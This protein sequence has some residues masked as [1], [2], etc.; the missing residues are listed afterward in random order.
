MKRAAIYFFYDVDGVVDRYVEY[1]IK[2]LHT[3]SDYLLVVVNGQ[4]QPNGRELFAD[5]ADDFFVRK[6]DMD[7]PAYKEGIE[8]ITW[9]KLL[10]YDELILA[11]STIYG[12]FRPLKAIF[13]E[14]DSIQCDYWGINRAYRDENRKKYCGYDLP[15]GYKPEEVITNFHV[16]RS[17]LL[18]SYEFRKHWDTLP[19]IKTY[20]DSILYHEMAFAVKMENAGFTFETLDH[21]IPANAYP[22]STVSGAYKMLSCYNVPFIRR[23]A[24]FDPNGSNFDYGPKVPRQVL[25]YI[26][27][28]SDYDVGMI[29]ENQLRTNSL[30]DLKNWVGLYRVVSPE[31]YTGREKP[32]ISFAVLLYLKDK[33]MLNEYAG[34]LG[35]FPSGTHVLLMCNSEED[36]NEIKCKSVFER[37]DIDAMTVTGS[38]GEVSAIIEGGTRLKNDGGYEAV[39]FLTDPVICEADFAVVGELYNMQC[40]EN[41]IG[42]ACYTENVLHIMEREPRA[43][44]II[45]EPPTHASYF[46][47]TGGTWENGENYRLVGEALKKLDR[48]VPYANDKPTIAPYGPAF[49]FR[50]AALDPLFR[51]PTDENIN[52]ILNN[53]DSEHL[54]FFRYLYPL[55]AQSNGYY[56]LNISET[57]NAEMELLHTTYMAQKMRQ[58]S[59]QIVTGRK[60]NTFSQL[61]NVLQEHIKQQKATHLVKPAMTA[62]KAN[63]LV[64]PAQPA[65]NAKQQQKKPTGSK[66]KRFVKA[67]MPKRLWNLLRKAKCKALGWGYVE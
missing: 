46:S 62:Q 39:C 13:A 37:F 30:Y 19:E 42:S 54:G 36:L 59:M 20:F 61:L 2:E 35:S 23:K 43:G 67:C 58:V 53:T 25:D 6:N 22:S 16:Y 24:I 55:I 33:D 10:D 41:A 7:A 56:S 18:H 44:M 45:P 8:Y 64:K 15:W 29:W 50:T 34:Y 4:L 65:Q 40:Y 48:K 28:Y 38:A 9:E 12:P 66:F 57:G 49:W 11:N 1:I 17:R 63:N 51:M 14:M 60:P 52:Y 5:I 26:S 21:N 47:Y 3:V 27:T 32:G 31:F